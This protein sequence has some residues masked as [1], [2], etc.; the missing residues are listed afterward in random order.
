MSIKVG[1]IRCQQTE[2]YCPATT[3]LSFAKEGK[4]GFE[5]L[6]PV[7]IVGVIT[8][9]GCPGKKAIK[10]A[11]MLKE[12][13]AE[14]IVLASCILRGTPSDIDYPCPFGKRMQDLIEEKTGLEVIEWTH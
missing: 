1:L 14:K 11:A 10:R 7:D 2:E 4:G 8:C 6:G 12:R 9:G 5:E 3:C 13:G